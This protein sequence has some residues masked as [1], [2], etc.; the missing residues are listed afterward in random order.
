MSSSYIDLYKGCKIN[1]DDNFVVEDIEEYLRTLPRSSWDDMQYIKNITALELTVKLQMPQSKLTTGVK[2]VD[3]YNYAEISNYDDEKK[4][5]FFITGRRWLSFNA[6]EFSLVADV[7]NTYKLNADYK[8]NKKTMI[9]REHRDRL[10]KNPYLIGAGKT[11]NDFANIQWQIS[12]TGA[13]NKYFI[14]T[15]EIDPTPR[16]V[17]RIVN[18]YV[19]GPEPV[20]FTYELTDRTSGNF[21]IEYTFADAPASLRLVFQWATALA[22]HYRLI[23]DVSESPGA[24]LYH[25]QNDDFVVAEPTDVSWNIL[26]TSRNEYDKTDPTAF[27]LNNPIDCY[28]YPDNPV[29]MK[30]YTG[31]GV[32][33]PNDFLEGSKYTI[34]AQNMGYRNAD[35]PNQNVDFKGNEDFAITSGKSQVAQISAPEKHLN[36]YEGQFVSIEKNNNKLDVV[37]YKYTSESALFGL[38][39]ANTFQIPVRTV[40]GLDQIKLETANDVICYIGASDQIKDVATYKAN[41]IGRGT[42]S[43]QTLNSIADVDRTDTRILKIIKLPYPPADITG[44]P[45][46]S[47]NSAMWIY[48]TAKKALKLVDINSRFGHDLDVAI[49]PLAELLITIPD[50]PTEQNRDDR[51]ESKLLHSD[52]LTQ[53]FVYDAFGLPIALERV[54]AANYLRAGRFKIKFAPTSTINSRFMFQFVDYVQKLAPEDYPDF[55]VVSRNNELTLYNSPYINYI[56]NGYNYDQKNKQIALA[57]NVIGLATGGANQGLS[58]YQLGQRTGAAGLGVPVASAALSL[59]GG[60]TNTIIGAINAERA[61][62]QKLKDLSM[63]SVSVAG[64]DD[65]DLLINYSQNRLKLCRYTAS[66]NV[67]RLYA[68]L[69]YYC[70]YQTQKQGTPSTDSRYWFNYVKCA[71]VFDD[72]APFSESIKDELARR[73]FEGVTILHHRAGAWDFE[74]V[75]ENWETSIL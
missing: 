73:Y 29:E 52:F 61:I 47:L 66:D 31:P 62:E 30:V 2:F 54:N 72:L 39:G 46:L 68:D 60:I 36:Y 12:D 67:R 65:I 8:F 25:N 51:F 15:F 10:A 32:L 22:D 42:E 21:Y 74:Q 24:P 28:L 64:S 50:N 13:R 43:V 5:Y 6:V 41:T 37:Q 4:Y 56:R 23:D 75:K 17:P 27:D 53:K 70:G 57:Q 14:S 58:L 63:Q 16:G 34:F 38:I 20:K 1:K 18:A 11:N 55:F 40:S 7:L 19:A 45:D 69:F 44:A 59:A 35:H 3:A 49:D 71:A 33:G 48:D 26:Y 9:E